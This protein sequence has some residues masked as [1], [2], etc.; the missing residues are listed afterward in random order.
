LKFGGVLGV[1]GKPGRVDLI[2]FISQFSELRCERY[3]FLSG[4]WC[5]KFKENPNFGFKRENQLSP[6]CVHTW[7]SGTGYTLVCNYNEVNLNKKL[8]SHT[9]SKSISNGAQYVTPDTKIYC[10]KSKCAG[11]SQEI[12]FSATNSCSLHVAGKRRHTV[13]H[14]QKRVINWTWLRL[15]ISDWSIIWL[16]QVICY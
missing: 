13:V 12:G 15:S 8:K 7:A 5:W 3:C 9:S 16:V 14:L 11:L 10:I 4:F 2:E 1:I 6:Q